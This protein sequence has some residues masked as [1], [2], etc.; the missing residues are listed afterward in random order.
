MHRDIQGI[1]FQGSVRGHP[2]KVASLGPYY[3]I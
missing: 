2:N 1:K 3:D